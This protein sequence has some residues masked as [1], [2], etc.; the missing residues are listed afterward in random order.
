MS[1]QELFDFAQVRYRQARNLI[2]DKIELIRK[3][4]P[5]FNAKDSYFQ[6][7]IIVQYI[8]LRV[9]LADG[10]FLEIEGEFIDQITDS[11]DILQLFDRHDANYNWSFAGALMTF[12]QIQSLVNRVEKLAKEHILAFSDLLAE[13]ERVDGGKECI[14]QILQCIN[15]IASAFIMADGNATAKEVEIATN[16]VQECLT[17]K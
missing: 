2:S 14:Q 8:L 10:K 12:Q 6:F 3:N 5:D 17:N 1:T 9:A 13:M 4:Y 11:Y 7:D 16:V 15:D